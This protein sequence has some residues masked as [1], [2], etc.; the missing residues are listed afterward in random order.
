MYLTELFKYMSDKQKADFTEGFYEAWDLDFEKD[1]S[2]GSCW[3]E[4]WNYLDRAEEDVDLQFSYYQAGVDF[5]NE[6]RE[7]IKDSR[8]N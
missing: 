6:M 3:G 8:G 2:P 5:F 1:Y 7:I 4:P